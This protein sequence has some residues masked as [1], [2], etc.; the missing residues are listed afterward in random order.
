MKLYGFLQIIAF[1]GLVLLL[2]KPMGAYM[3][4]VFAGERTLLSPVLRPVE[5]LFYRLFRVSEEEDM[6]WT[7]YGLALL[8][9]SLVGGLVTYALLR[10]QGYLPLN[11]QH[12][13]GVQATP[14]LSFNAAMSFVTNTNWQNYSP[15]ATL[16]YFS[17]MVA[18]AIHNW[19]SAAA[20]IAV[21]LAV[22]RGF[23]RHSANGLGNFWV[24][25]TRGSLYVLLPICTIYAL[26]L[27]W[28]G[29][30]QNFTPYTQATT[31][32]G[33]T[34]TI[35][36]GPVASQEA[37]K[38]LGTNG[39][40]FF[41]A[42][43]SHPYENPT[44]LSNF[45]E[46]LSIFLIPAGLT[47]TFGR[48]VGNTRQGWALFGAMALLFAGGLAVCYW[49]EA[50]GN[51]TVT[52][53]GVM[54]DATAGQPG[55]NMEGK[56]VRFGIGASTLF[57]TV[58]T[59]ASCG[60][61][62]SMHDSYTPLGGAVPLI[63]ILCDETVFGGVGAGLF[64]MLMYAVVAVFIA[65]LMVGRTPEYVG[66]KI[67]KF[68]VRMAVLAVLTLFANVVFWTALA[69]TVKLPPGSAAVTFADARQE[70]AFLRAHPGAVWNHVNGSSPSTY[71]GAPRNNTNNAGAH[72]FSEILYSYASQTGNNGS[73]FAGLTGNTPYYNLTGGLAM[74]VGRFLMIIPLLALAGSLARKKV[75]PASA[76]TLATDSATFAL[77]LVAVVLIVGALEY[78]PALSLGPIV[79]H[80]QMLGGK[81]F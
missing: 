59:D 21:A 20:G 67:E 76:G 35:A 29:V 53:L 73:A 65:G 9:F 40:G 8:A 27:V 31:V 5:R 78:L 60:A 28:Q 48:M 30:P 75:T 51:P 15:E 62:N 74:L 54:A 32:E 72:G 68:E 11:P 71:N 33:A 61:V 4:R 58:T 13:S 49:A 47:Y 7:T 1:F 45:L 17:N 38:M 70:A 43:S 77:L 52:R 37:I 19:M 69:M 44:P 66:K 16:S 63:N 24:D 57:A 23:A 22:V 18:L 2:T 80:F 25:I 39:G 6:R 46:I 64:G 42:N 81:L 56:E 36:Q 79:E 41:N 14:D 3:A 55:G 34:Q 50:G 12:F 10:L 26:V